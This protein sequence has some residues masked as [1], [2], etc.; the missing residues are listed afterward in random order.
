MNEDMQDFVT[1]TPSGAVEQSSKKS[2][3]GGG[4]GK[5]FL[6]HS[7]TTK[8]GLELPDGDYPPPWP[9]NRQYCDSYSAKKSGIR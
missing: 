9:Q 6:R 1:G 5:P 4:G 2:G 8:F 3:G 7:G